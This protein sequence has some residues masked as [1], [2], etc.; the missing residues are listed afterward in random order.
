[1]TDLGP[2]ISLGKVLEVF[3]DT[4][5]A[6]VTILASSD[7][8]FGKIFECKILALRLDNFG[9]ASV[10]LPM[11]Q[12][13][14]YVST[15]FS[16]SFPSIVGYETAPREQTL[17]TEHQARLTP[18]TPTTDTTMPTGTNSIRGKAPADAL[19]GDDFKTGTD[20][21]ALA[22]LTGG[23]VIA[24][25]TELC[26]L[27]LTKTR[28]TATL[29]AR[30]LKIFTDFGEIIS[31]SENGSATLAIRGNTQVKKN[32]SAEA[33][34][35][36]IQLGGKKS[37]QATL[38]NKFNLTIDHAGHTAIN[39]TSQNTILTQH[40]STTIGGSSNLAV[41]ASKITTIGK[42]KHLLI[43]GSQQRTVE[44][45]DTFTVLGS[46]LKSV[47]GKNELKTSSVSIET[48]DGIGRAAKDPDA[49]QILIG[50]GNFKVKVGSLNLGSTP[51]LILAPKTGNF[52]IEVLNGDI[53]QNTY[54]GDVI[55]S[56]FKGDASLATLN[57][58]AKLQ[59]SIGNTVA[60]TIKGN[61]ILSSD[62]GNASVKA[63]VGNAELEG[64]IAQ[65]KANSRLLSGDSS[66]DHVVTAMKLS[67]QLFIK[68]ATVFN[69]HS[70][71]VT[72]LIGGP[73]SPP[74]STMSKISP[75]AM[76]NNPKTMA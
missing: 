11:P 14:V 37:L 40:A 60:S 33:H 63:P 22:I 46:S 10:S 42:D 52:L 25:A 31:D 12:D 44:D 16:T 72:P 71:I 7:E 28:A 61:A 57:G 6:T 66:T 23:S 4:Y 2:N 20:G 55:F 65:L 35:T 74:T 15:Q 13:R 17:P 38:S 21:Q 18:F 73:T 47:T 43:K 29:V 50:K 54:V 34:E 68:I 67:T 64:A 45:S 59:T 76:S 5:T 26:Q 32:T 27:L 75:T 69:S 39:A 51:P 48:I 19:P 58:D 41:E 9:A 8:T 30:R 53:K 1:M 49:K 62:L 24:K 36:D 56:T 70:H 3:P